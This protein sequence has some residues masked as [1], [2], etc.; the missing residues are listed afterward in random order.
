MRVLAHVNA[1]GI[2]QVR[3]T[4]RARG[5]L[6]IRSW[7]NSLSSI[8]CKYLFKNTLC[9]DVFVKT[10][11]ACFGTIREEVVVRRKNEICET[12]G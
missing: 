5:Q 8:L 2:R 11:L 6:Q 12:P 9:I 3:E 4:C 10:V 1:G 7:N